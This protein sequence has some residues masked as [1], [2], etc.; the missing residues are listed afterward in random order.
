[1]PNDPVFPLPQLRIIGTL[2][3]LMLAI[4]GD[5]AKEEKKLLETFLRDY[6]H[7]TFGEYKNTLAQI[8]TIGHSIYA[9]P[10][11]KLDKIDRVLVKLND[12]LSRPQKEVVVDF[13]RQVMT[14]D[15]VI[16][17]EEKMLYEHI[18]RGLNVR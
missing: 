7:Y 13:A 2:G 1:M 15:D 16:E 9:D 14:A 18:Q 10:G 4:D 5:I 3:F 6:W 12:L 8:E 11:T 17:A